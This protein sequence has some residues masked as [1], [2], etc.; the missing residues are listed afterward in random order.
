[1]DC[2]NILQKIST[3]WSQVVDFIEVVAGEKSDSGLVRIGGVWFSMS[4]PH[5]LEGAVLLMESDEIRL[6]STRENP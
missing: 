6:S 3:Q 4:S 1:M 5:C 2:K